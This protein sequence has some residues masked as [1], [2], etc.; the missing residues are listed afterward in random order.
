MNQTTQRTE[1][2]VERCFQI[3]VCGKNAFYGVFEDAF[4]KLANAGRPSE[5]LASVSQRQLEARLASAMKALQDSISPEPE[6][7]GMNAPAVD[8]RRYFRTLSPIFTAIQIAE[9]NLAEREIPD[10]LL[11]TM[12]RGAANAFTDPTA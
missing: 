1:I 5:M 12:W 7:A 11:A 3:Y 6:F 10:G 9:Q 4:E 2:P 8:Q